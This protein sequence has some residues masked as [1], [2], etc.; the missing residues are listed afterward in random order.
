MVPH[1]YNDIRDLSEIAR[2]VYE[3][4]KMPLKELF[5]I[6]EE[7]ISGYIKGDRKR[8]KKAYEVGKKYHAGQKRKS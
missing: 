1:K 8:I 4:E 6:L 2:Q 7:K 3:Y 5:S